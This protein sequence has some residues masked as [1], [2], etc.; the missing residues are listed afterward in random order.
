M[1]GQL[2]LLFSLVSTLRPALF[3]PFF[4]AFCI[5]ST[6]ISL[7][8]TFYIFFLLPSAMNLE[9]EHTT[10]RIFYFFAPPER[11]SDRL[12]LFFNT[13]SFL[14]LSLTIS[15][16]LFLSHFSS[17]QSSRWGVDIS[18]GSDCKGCWG[19]RKGADSGGG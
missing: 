11:S 17:G 14:S 1:C 10:G 13:V 16:C 3:V 19:K 12:R 7:S 4:V 18:P 9:V 8:P 2:G 15:L 6:W 5:I